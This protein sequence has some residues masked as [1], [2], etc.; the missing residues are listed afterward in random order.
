MKIKTNIA[1][2]KAMAVG[3]KYQQAVEKINSEMRE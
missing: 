1:R 3:I 2:I